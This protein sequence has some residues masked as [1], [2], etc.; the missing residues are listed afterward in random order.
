MHIFVIT[1]ILKPRIGVLD[2][3]TRYTQTL[4]TIQSIKD[5][6]PGAMIIMIDSSP[7][8]LGQTIVDD[9]KSKVDYLVPLNKHKQSVELANKGLKSPG[10]CYIMVIALDI[11]KN[12]GLPKVDRIFK[13]TGRAE[14]NDNFHIE[15]Y[16]NP[17]M[18]GKFVFKTPVVSWMSQ[19]LKLVDTRLWSFD[20][21]L[22]DDVDGTLIRPA[23]EETMKGRLDLEHAYYKFLPKELLFEKDVIGLTC[24]LASCG[25]IINE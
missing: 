4:K 20:Y 3:V 11:I 19:H 7:D 13:I 2:P 1:S 12:L 23:Y 22:L 17:D 24:Q 8:E 18:K 15:D 5:K 10:E 14:L 16:N 6:A 21:N 9:L 25:T